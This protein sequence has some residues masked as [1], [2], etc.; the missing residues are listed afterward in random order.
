MANS[1][2][3]QPFVQVNW[4]KG[5][6]EASGRPIINP[7][8][9]YSKDTVQ[10]TPGPGGAH[11]WSPM[12]FN[13]ATGLVYIPATTTGSFGDAVDPNFK[14]KPGSQNMG[15]VFSFGPPPAGAKA[16]TAPPMTGPKPP[17]GERGA[18]IA[19]DPV[20]QTQKWMAP[21][22][23]GIGGGTVTTAGNLVIQV[24]PDGRMVAYSADKGEKLLDVQTG[25][26]GGMGP[27]ITYEMDGKQ[28][29]TLSGGTGAVNFGPPGGG[30]GGRGG[31]A[32]PAPAPP[33]PPAAPAPAVPA[34]ATPAAPATCGDGIHVQVG[35][36]NPAPPPPPPGFGGGPT[37]M[38]KM[39][40]F[41]LDG[42][43][44]LPTPPAAK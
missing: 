34:P 8:A 18:L 29:I 6:D 30:G 37:A 23:G 36:A 14:F 19:W 24:I 9:H 22:G 20:T 35:G 11:N 26:R 7:E 25:L 16:A 17:E 5:L 44:P 43:A 28:Y 2:S 3:G 39:L 13:P 38:P 32:A 41:V 15:T 40:T 10:I 4:A 21:G 42:K 27:P 12:S 33:P 31:A 1:F